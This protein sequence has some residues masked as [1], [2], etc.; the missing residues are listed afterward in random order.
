LF[1]KVGDNKCGN[2]PADAAPVD[3]KHPASHSPH[4]KISTP[5]R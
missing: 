5:S 3:G 4:L 1:F 2:N